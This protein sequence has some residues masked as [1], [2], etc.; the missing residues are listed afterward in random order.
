MSKDAFAS[1]I[2]G[3]D[4]SFWTDLFFKIHPTPTDILF[5]SGTNGC[6]VFDCLWSLQSAL[7]TSPRTLCP[8]S[9]VSPVQ[10]TGEEEG[11]CPFYP[12]SFTRNLWV[13]SLPLWSCL[14]NDN[15]ETKFGSMA[16]P[17]DFKIIQVAFPAAL[18]SVQS[19]TMI[20]SAMN[21]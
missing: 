14:S 18:S 8:Y 20:Q 21:N 4:W 7:L 2:E 6:L 1:S 9:P 19:P 11:L 5:Q 13:Q 16:I 10:D 12:L 15:N 17:I 3:L